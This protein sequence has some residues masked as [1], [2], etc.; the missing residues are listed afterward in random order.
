MDQRQEASGAAGLSTAPEH[1]ELVL[2][3]REQLREC[4]CTHACLCAP[5]CV[6]MFACTRVHVGVPPSVAPFFFLPAFGISLQEGPLPVWVLKTVLAS[7]Q[8]DLWNF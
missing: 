6:C 5:V 7:S 3:G 1:R 8:T 2:R 4:E